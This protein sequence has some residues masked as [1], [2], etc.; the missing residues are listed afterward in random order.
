MLAVEASTD[1]ANNRSG[2]A[3]IFGNF[4]TVTASGGGFDN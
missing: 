3:L 4:A 2:K 1:E